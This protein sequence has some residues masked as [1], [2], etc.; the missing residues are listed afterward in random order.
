MREREI[1]PAKVYGV[2]TGRERNL[3][4]LLGDVCREMTED[5]REA[6][7]AAIGVLQ[8]LFR[9]PVFLREVR[10]C[11]FPGGYDAPMVEEDERKEARDHLAKVGIQIPLSEPAFQADVR[12]GVEGEEVLAQLVLERFGVGG[13]VLETT[14]TRLEEKG[15]S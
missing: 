15:K 5:E 11:G 13:L 7:R 14:Q 10:E 6:S 9:R 3:Y 12:K 2:A 8:R 4:E 1:P